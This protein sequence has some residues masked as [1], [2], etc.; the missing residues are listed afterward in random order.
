MSCMEVVITKFPN[1]K[2]DII[3]LKKYS[4]GIREVF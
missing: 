4:V 1:Q 3:S 2:Y